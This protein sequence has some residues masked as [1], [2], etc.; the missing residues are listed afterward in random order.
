[1][2]MARDVLLKHMQEPLGDYLQTY[3]E[4][5]DLH[6]IEITCVCW[7]SVY[8]RWSFEYDWSLLE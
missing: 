5:A 1:M 7:L 3:D 2:K 4:I 8:R 6:Y